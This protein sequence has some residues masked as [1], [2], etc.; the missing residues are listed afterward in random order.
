MCHGAVPRRGEHS[1]AEWW[2]MTLRIVK[3]YKKG[4]N[5][6][7]IFGTWIIWKHRNACVFYG[8]SPSVSSIIRDFKNEH[9]LWCMAG[10][11]KLEGFGLGGGVLV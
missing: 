10:A 11:K 3:E 4:V 5:S 7:I 9:S 8:A 1:F 2:R 6:L